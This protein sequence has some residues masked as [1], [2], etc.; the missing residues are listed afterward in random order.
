MTLLDGDALEIDGVGFAGVKGL[1]GGFGQRALQPWG[2]DIMK[3]FVREAVDEALKLESGLAKLRTSQRVVVL[4]YSPVRDTVEGEPLGDFPVPRVEPP[5]GAAPALSGE[6]GLSRPCAS[7]QARR[8]NAD[9][10]ARL[11]RLPAPAP[12]SCSGAAGLSPRRPRP[13][14]GDSGRGDLGLG[15]S[16]PAELALAV[17]ASSRGTRRNGRRASRDGSEARARSPSPGE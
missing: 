11:Q 7:G 12:R 3:R 15:V 17:R 4:H 14:G 6:R 5:R 9:R 13:A 2:E 1:G 10:G 16:P 8:A